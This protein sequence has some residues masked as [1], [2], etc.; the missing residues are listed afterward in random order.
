RVKDDLNRLLTA[1]FGT[2][3]HPRM[4]RNANA[5]AT[6]ATTAKGLLEALSVPE[7]AG[8][9]VNTATTFG[10]RANVVPA[11]LEAARAAYRDHHAANRARMTA[12]SDVAG[13]RAD[14]LAHLQAIRDDVRPQEDG[15]RD[16]RQTRDLDR[17]DLCRKLGYVPGD[18]NASDRNLK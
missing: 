8:L 2:A 4:P 18:A 1:S 16:N 3:D 9:G 10:E 6:A 11:E 14:A 17:P 13:F 7:V 15:G 5:L 12:L